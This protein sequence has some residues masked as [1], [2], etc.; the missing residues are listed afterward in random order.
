MPAMNRGEAS[1]ARYRRQRYLDLRRVGAF[2]LGHGNDAVATAIGEQAGAGLRVAA[3]H[4]RAD[5]ANSP[6]SRRG[7]KARVFL[8]PAGEANERRQDVADDHRPQQS[9]QLLSLVPWFVAKGASSLT[10]E[11]R[12]WAGSRVGQVHQVR[13][14]VPY[15]GRSIPAIA[16]VN[17]RRAPTWSD[18]RIVGV[19][20]SMEPV[21]GSN[22]VVVI[23][24]LAGAR[25][26]QVRHHADLRRSHDRL[27][28]HRRRCS[29]R[30]DRARLYHVCQGVLA[31]PLSGVLAEVASYSTPMR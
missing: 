23:G 17:A 19:A 4:R 28:P 30:F 27:R 22:G 6:S 11:S 10:G 31:C 2:N 24:R 8:R 16:K 13:G 21:V 20:P 14:A 29:V 18:L 3:V 26:R 7:T 15:D 1:T 9:A 25:Q 5:L 12:R